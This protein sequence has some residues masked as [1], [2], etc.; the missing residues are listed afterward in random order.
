MALQGGL[1]PPPDP[2]DGSG[3]PCGPDCHVIQDALAN[4][5]GP[6]DPHACHAFE[7]LDCNDYTV[8]NDG[9]V[10]GTDGQTYS[11]HCEF[12][13]SRCHHPLDPHAPDG[14]HLYSQGSCP[15]NMVVTSTPAGP[16]HPP[17]P[18][19]PDPHCGP[20]CDTIN[21]ALQTI[22]AHFDEHICRPFDHINCADHVLTN[23]EQICG[24]DGR[25]Y[26]THCE[27][28]KA[29][30]K[31]I[32]D[33]HSHH[34]LN[35][36]S[37]GPCTSPTST[38]TVVTAT[39]KLITSTVPSTTVQVTSQS[40]TNTGVSSTVDP[41]NNVLGNVF[42]S[43]NDQIDCSISYELTCGTDGV[44]YPNKCSLMKAICLN[45]SLHETGLMN[46]S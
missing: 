31:Y 37:H 46:C 36:R 15:S 11:S 14:L 29:R 45:H 1:A 24:T 7:R 8:T 21:K 32:L 20:E 23:D 41:S 16:H 22:G 18:H 39:T 17:D 19:Q 9:P 10:C 6:L 3:H 38:S 44:L 34:T 40:Q 28:V 13:K 5:E 35:V 2:L 43:L 42:C 33:H 12:V 27:F 26:N 25:T 4:L 30:C